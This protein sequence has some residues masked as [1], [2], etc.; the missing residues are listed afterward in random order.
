MPCA[1]ASSSM[2]RMCAVLAIIGCSRRAANV[3]H[4]HVVFLVRAGRQ[5]VDAGRMRE[6]LVLAGQRRRRHVR[7]HEA[8]VQPGVGGQERRQ[9]RHAGVDQHRDAALGDRADLGDREG[10]RVGGQRDRLGVEVAARDHRIAVVVRRTPAGCRS[11]HWLRAAAPARR[12]ATGRGRRRPPA[13]GSA[14]STGPARGRRRA[15]AS[16]GSR[17]R[18]AARGS[19]VRR[20]SAPAGRAAHGCAGR[21]GRRCRARHRPSAR[22]RR[23]PPRAPARSRAAHAAPA[24]SRS[25]CR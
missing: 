10:H 24:R 25:A 1:A 19:T 21:T 8:A 23:A 5:A 16:G 14:A 6:R 9:P 12:G 13:A 18:R 15:G 2:P 22:R 3:G 7:D 17:C 20:R 11:P 4:R